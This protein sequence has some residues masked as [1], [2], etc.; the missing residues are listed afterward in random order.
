MRLITAPRLRE[1]AKLHPLAG[2][3]LRRWLQIVKAA[4]WKNPEDVKKS[5]SSVNFVRVA[6]G[7]TVG[8]FN[9]AGNNFRLIAA[10]HHN[11]QKVFVLRF[12]PHH[13]YSKDD[14]KDHL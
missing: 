3:S 1:Y 12:Y 2:P 7:R 13:E 6:S 10:I 14:W 9:I 4:N 8:V 11:T 5:W